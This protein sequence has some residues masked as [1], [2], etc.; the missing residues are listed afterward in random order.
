MGENNDTWA[1]K[2]KEIHKMKR[3]QEGEGEGDD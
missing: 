3:R 1:K 2:K